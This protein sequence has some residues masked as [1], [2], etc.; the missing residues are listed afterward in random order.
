[1]KTE[2]FKARKQIQLRLKHKIRNVKRTAI[3]RK[4]Y[5]SNLKTQLSSITNLGYEG[6]KKDKKQIMKNF[7]NFIE[8]YD[9]LKGLEDIDLPYEQ[10]LMYVRHKSIKPDNHKAYWVKMKRT[11]STYSHVATTPHIKNPIIMNNL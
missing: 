6:K 5:L 1:M 8:K 11:N 7:S 4:Q 10:N 2:F 9:Q 3:T